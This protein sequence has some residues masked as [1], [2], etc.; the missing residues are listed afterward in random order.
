MCD[1]TAAHQYIPLSGH[2]SLDEGQMLCMPLFWSQR[3][4]AA[5]KVVDTHEIA[6]FAATTGI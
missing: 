1:A 5:V 3:F 2:G 4:V 6:S